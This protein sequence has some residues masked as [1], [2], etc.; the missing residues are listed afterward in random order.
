MSGTRKTR[1]PA[2]CG[3]VFARKCSALDGAGVWASPVVE[4]ARLKVTILLNMRCL[5]VDIGI[6]EG[7]ALALQPG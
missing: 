2:S 6:G 7:A 3:T 4:I 1:K 5:V